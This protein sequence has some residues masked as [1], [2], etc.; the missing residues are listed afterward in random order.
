[1]SRRRGFTL[2]ELLVV[3][4]IIAILIAILLPAVQQAR[5]AARRTSCKNNLKQIAL[6]LHNYHEQNNALPMASHWFLKFYSAFTA[7]LPNTDQAPLFA[8]YD[9]NLGYSSTTNRP[10]LGTNIPTFRCP[11][12]VLTRQA[13]N[14][15]CNEFLAAASYAVSVGSL[16]AWGPVNNGALVQHD[17]GTVGLRNITDGTS[18]T[19][20]VGELDYGLKNYMFTSGPC[21][22]QHRGGVTA[23]GMGYPGY[24][25]AT[26]V[27]VFN[28]DM[29]ITGANEFQTFRSDHVGGVQFALADGSVHFISSFI[30]ADLLDRLATRAGGEVADF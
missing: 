2:I 14:A 1:M 26:T 24:S 5:E 3:I 19:L 7:I 16:D 4:A 9:P 20:M 10:V 17:K 21:L 27:G 11:A 23:W 13:P 29:Q 30:N 6:A 28:S 22:G 18:N 15:S 8:D 25:I 12:M